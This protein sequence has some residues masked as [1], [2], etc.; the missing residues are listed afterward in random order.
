MREKNVLCVCNTYYQLLF[1]IQL[2]RTVFCNEKMFVIL[3]D[4]SRNT[5]K[6]ADN[7][8]N[9]HDLFD[10]VFYV[11][12]RKIDYSESRMFHFRVMMNLLIGKDKMLRFLEEIPVADIILYYNYTFSTRLIYA[13]LSHKNKNLICMR[14]E[15]GLPSYQFELEHKAGK[16]NQ[17]AYRFLHLFGVVTLEERTK[18]FLCYFP[19]MYRGKMKPIGIEPI[20][21]EDKSLSELL[22]RV[23]FVSDIESQYD[24]EYIYFASSIDFD[25][26]VMVEFDLVEKLAGLIGKENLL[27]KV[28]P[29]DRRNIYKENGYQV[30]GNSSIPWEALQFHVGIAGKKL[31]STFSS[32]AISS[33][34]MIRSGVESYYLYNLCD[35]PNH[36]VIRLVEVLDDTIKR[37]HNIG[38]FSKIKIVSELEE[39]LSDNEELGVR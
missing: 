37:M 24:K 39:I 8:N 13:M 21:I 20:Q 22:G 1:A 32:S 5:K 26:D 36:D 34:L 30:D 10:H 27:I 9:E 4:H 2:K 11:K 18:L 17:M 31:L 16:I 7:L 6:V 12:T 19:Q 28:H 15:E 3:S 35:C 38:G 14:F 33:N 29:R 23:F 25:N